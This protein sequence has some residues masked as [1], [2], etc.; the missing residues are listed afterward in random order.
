MLFYCFQSCRINAHMCIRSIH[1]EL[2]LL[3]LINGWMFLFSTKQLRRFVP[4]SLTFIA[5]SIFV[6]ICCF[7]DFKMIYKFKSSANTLTERFLKC[8]PVFK[9]ISVWECECKCTNTMQSKISY[10]I[11][12]PQKCNLYGSREL[13]QLIIVPGN[14]SHLAIAK[15]YI[16]IQNL[17]RS[18]AQNR[19]NWMQR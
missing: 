18:L 10:K 13:T 3:T 16:L 6:G 4:L 14:K 1:N 17:T 5:G 19:M 8:F 15:I 7:F 12:F 11:S 2:I 9:C